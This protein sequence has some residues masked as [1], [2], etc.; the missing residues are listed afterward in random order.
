[1]PRKK[2]TP[3]AKPPEPAQGSAPAAKELLARVMLRTADKYDDAAMRAAGERGEGGEGQ[4]SRVR[5]I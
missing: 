1:M 3:A 5:H 4:R 2:P